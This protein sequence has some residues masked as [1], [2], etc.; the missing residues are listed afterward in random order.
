[1]IERQELF[2]LLAISPEDQS[3]CNTLLNASPSRG[4]LVALATLRSRLGSFARGG[5]EV[6]LREGSP[7]ALAPSESDWTSALLLFAPELLD[8]HAALGIPQEISQATVADL[9]LNLAINR[10]VHGR[11]GL[12]TWSWLT[13]HAAGN[14]FR[15]GRLQYHLVPSEAP[16]TAGKPTRAWEL[17]IHIPED[18]SLSPAAVGASLEQAVEFF[19]RYFPDKTVTQGRCVSWLL[20]PELAK[21]LPGS[22][23]AKFA[24]RF[25]LER[26]D[27]DSRDAV[28]FTFRQRGLDGLERLPRDT[29]LQRAVLD[30]LN[31]G[32]S[33]QVGH[34]YLDLVAG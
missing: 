14:L 21:R 34:G 26:L 9:G 3:G 16:P 31:D 29:A 15:V 4:T 28:Y 33:W 27:G 6:F 2:D 20:D 30:H 10:R 32:G 8:H 17:G 7:R 25:T 24:Q 12:E 13:L 18:G 5:A 11:F 22:N 19:V 1:M 23:I